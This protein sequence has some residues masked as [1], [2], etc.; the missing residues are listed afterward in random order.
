MEIKNDRLV[1]FLKEIDKELERDIKL[2]AVGGT[3][4]TLLGLKT[5][6]L[7]IDFDMNDA[8]LTELE[9]ILKSTPH[10]FKVDLY[11]NGLIFSQQLPKD[12]VSKLILI[13]ADLMRIKL[14]ALNPVDIVVT[15]IGRL[16][17]RDIQDIESCIKKHTLKKA[18]IINRAKQVVYIGREETYEENLR[19]VIKK[20]FKYKGSP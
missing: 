1:N 19:F 2:H 20:F 16:N 6:T 7:D 15:K 12:Y 11:K 4:M 14:Y 18:A 13:P 5:S 17:D 8:D 10:G 3:A 9:R